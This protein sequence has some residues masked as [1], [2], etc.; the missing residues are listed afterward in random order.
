VA[1]ENLRA[2]LTPRYDSDLDGIEGPDVR[3]SLTDRVIRTTGTDHC[4]WDTIPTVHR[5]FF[6]KLAPK[7]QP[8]REGHEDVE[9]ASE[10]RI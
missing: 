3:R 9:F 7:S 2:G 4:P 10:K 8:L 6:R 5:V 1:S